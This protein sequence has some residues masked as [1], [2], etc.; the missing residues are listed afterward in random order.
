M[1]PINNLISNWC[2]GFRTAALR[3]HNDRRRTSRS[4]PTSTVEEA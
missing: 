3:D 2:Q 1:L 4:S